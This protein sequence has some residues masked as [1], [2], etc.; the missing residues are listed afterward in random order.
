M[1][2]KKSFIN[3]SVTLVIRG[4]KYY[5]EHVVNFAVSQYTI[6]MRRSLCLKGT[7]HCM[8]FV[9]FYFLPNIR[10]SRQLHIIRKVLIQKWLIQHRPTANMHEI[11]SGQKVM[12]LTLLDY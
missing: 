4:I 8:N 5:R 3:T 10:V 6:V 9:S 12:Q 2:E 1:Q 7:M 11:H